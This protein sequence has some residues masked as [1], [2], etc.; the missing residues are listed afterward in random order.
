[1]NSVLYVSLF[2]DLR[3]SDQN[4]QIQDFLLWSMFFLCRCGCHSINIVKM[5]VYHIKH[6]RHLFHS[7][8]MGRMIVD[9]DKVFRFFSTA[10]SIG[11]SPAYLLI[12][13]NLKIYL[14][15]LSM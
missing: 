9:G 1:M 7:I 11:G 12:I 5:F 14:D 10:I 3:V 2:Q 6:F 13:I 15:E 8:D 4:I